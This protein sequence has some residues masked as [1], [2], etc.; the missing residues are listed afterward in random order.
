MKS[1]IPH[2]LTHTTDPNGVAVVGVRL[3]NRAK[4]AWLYLSDYLRIIKQ[5]GT[6]VWAVSGNGKGLLYVRFRAPGQSN[7]K[8]N[9]ARLVAG[10]FEKTGVRYLDGNP[11]NLRNAN[12]IHDKGRGGRPSRFS[13]LMIP[14][15]K[16]TARG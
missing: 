4:V 3:S 10:D 13:G 6:P 5:Y 8:L 2:E 7:N 9:V 1:Q 12:L 16:G 15:G 11:L 14:T